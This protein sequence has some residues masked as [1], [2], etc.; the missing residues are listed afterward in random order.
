MVTEIAHPTAGAVP[1]VASPVRF[2]DETPQPYRH[3]PLLGEHTVEVLTEAGFGQ[4]QIAAWLAD[5][6]VAGRE[7]NAG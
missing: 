2:T 3:P 4:Q 1:L 5:G 7:H 6:T